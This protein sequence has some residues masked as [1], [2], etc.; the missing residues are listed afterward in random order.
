VIFVLLEAADYNNS[1]YA[2]DA[3]DPYRHSA[4]VDCSRQTRWLRIE[5]THSHI[6]RHW[7]RA[8]IW[9][10]RLAHRHSSY[11]ACTTGVSR[12]FDLYLSGQLTQL[13][14]P[15]RRTVFL[16]RATQESLSGRT[17]DR[18]AAWNKRLL[19]LAKAIL[20]TAG[21]SDRLRSRFRRSLPISKASS[22]VNRGS[23][24][25][26]S[27]FRISSNCIGQHN[28]LVGLCL[29]STLRTASRRGTAGMVAEER[30]FPAAEDRAGCRCSWQK[31]STMVEA[32][33]EIKQLT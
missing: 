26:R 4:A 16:F 9:P 11:C 6:H 13:E 17:P 33:T 2:F 3:L 7:R 27:C 19:L 20:T 30:E 29:A 15:H 22:A 14:T 10:R 21:C 5:S 8:C 24:S 12:G 18:E 32:S 25:P 31:V 1:N 28:H 23:V